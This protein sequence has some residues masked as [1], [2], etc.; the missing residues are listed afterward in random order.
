MLSFQKV[1]LNNLF[2]K[3][4]T[5]EMLDRYRILDIYPTTLTWTY[6]YHLHGKYTCIV[7]SRAVK[8]FLFQIYQNNQFIL[9]KI[10]YTNIEIENLFKEITGIKLK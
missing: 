6:T 4:L 10:V 3:N 2:K 1:K 7:I 8:G 5:I 9:L